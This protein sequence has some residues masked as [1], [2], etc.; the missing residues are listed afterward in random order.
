MF[1]GIADDEELDIDITD[2]DGGTDSTFRNRKS[3]TASIE[4]IANNAF[5]AK[6]TRLLSKALT[7]IHLPGKFF[8]CRNLFLRIVIFSF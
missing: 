4:I 8:L 5:S 1:N 2:D 7:H 6:H 3:S